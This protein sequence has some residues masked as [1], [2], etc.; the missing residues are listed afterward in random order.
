MTPEDNSSDA[1]VVIVLHYRGVDDTMACLA[2]I[3]E[4][5]AA[6]VRVLLVD[7]GSG[8]DIAARL[9]ARFADVAVLTLPENRGW[10]GGNNE[11]IA[12]AMQRGAAFVC[13]LNN[14]TLIA[15]GS[16]TALLRR[17]RE[18]HPCL[19]QP[20]IDYL[21][22]AEGAQIDPAQ[23]SGYA[24]LRA[25]DSVYA[26]DFAY[27]ACLM[28][29]VSVFRMIGVFDERFF[30]QLE[31]TDFY[32]RARRRGIP[33]LCDVGVRIRHAES[34]SF[35][36]RVTPDKTYYLV[37]NSLLL[38]ARNA[39]RPGI[40]IGVLRRAYWGV[41]ARGALGEKPAAWRV[42]VWLLSGHDHACAA[43]DGIRDFVFRRFGA[44][45]RW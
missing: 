32:Y 21:D 34:R 27:G 33:S 14:D 13:L 25:G 24:P 31:E 22:P 45:R 5:R 12:W 23:W 38:A 28:I 35:G 20:A 4:D 6:P 9:Q 29:P 41:S 39:V 3:F 30:L 10:A 43:R 36:G 19:V 15:P 1:L 26:L 37:R 18:A 40:A 8:D 11:G 16:F 42:L 2:S 17:S 7:N 44:R